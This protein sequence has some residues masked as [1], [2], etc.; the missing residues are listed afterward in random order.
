MSIRI[1]IVED[2]VN[3]RKALANMV[4]YYCDDIEIIGEA[5][6]VRQGIEMISSDPPD[7]VLLDVRLP[8]G[9]GF[10][11]IEKVRQRNFKVVFITAYNE[12]AIKAI[13]LS[14]LD[15]ILKPVKPADLRIAISKARDAIEQDERMNLQVDTCIDNFK[16]MTREKKIILN[17]AESIHV[18]E[19]SKLIRCESNENYTRIIIEG[20]KNI[21]VARTLKEFEEMLNPFGFF[22]THQS[23]LVNLKHVETYEKSTGQA[24]LVDGTHIPVAVRKKEMFLRALESYLLA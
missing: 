18:V 16:G 20:K 7:L 6:D 21:M 15:Y 1:L 17:T 3:A 8:D 24:L 4:H 2:E 10:D 12:Y 11:L 19:L 22:R 13:K 23:H 5:K 14:A 9:T